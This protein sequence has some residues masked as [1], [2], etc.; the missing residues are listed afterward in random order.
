VADTWTMIDRALRFAP[1][2]SDHAILCFD[3][4]GDFQ[5]HWQALITD[6]AAG[7]CGL[8]L[9]AHPRATEG[10]ILRVQLG[11]RDPVRARVVWTR[12]VPPGLVQVGMQYLE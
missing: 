9:F 8:V 4:E 10:T 3:P 2:P 11:R 6:Q 12:A 5:P 7:G 1:S